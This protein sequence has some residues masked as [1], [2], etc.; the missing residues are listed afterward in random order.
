MWA[1]RHLSDLGSEAK[2]AEEDLLHCNRCDPDVRVRAWA[3]VALVSLGHDAN[4][5]LKAV[6]SLKAPTDVM[7]EDADVIEM[8]VLAALDEIRRVTIH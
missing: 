3:A 4:A 6:Q 8:E 5:L 7:S 1:C 2:V